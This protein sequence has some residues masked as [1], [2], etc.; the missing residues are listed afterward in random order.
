MICSFSESGI[1]LNMEKLKYYTNYKSKRFYPGAIFLNKN[2]KD[3]KLI[4]LGKSCYN[5]KSKHFIVV[6]FINTGFI[7]R[8]NTTQ[9]EH[10]IIDPY[11][12]SVYGKG[13]RG[14]GSYVTCKNY[15]QTKL[16]TLWYNML[17]RCYSSSYLEKTPSYIGCEVCKEWLNFQIFCKDIQTLPN[18]NNWEKDS[19]A[20]QLDKDYVDSNNKIYCKEKCSF[21]PTV[22]N[23]VLS[24]Y[25]VS[26]YKG[27]SPEGEEYLF[28]NMRLFAEEHG[29]TR[30]G[31]SSVISGRQKS[32]RGW[33]F[34]LIERKNKTF[35][36]E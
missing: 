24:N 15:K 28:S 2:T 32:H 3:Q 14:E 8:I 34:Y 4:V 26:K 11:E 9:L 18:Y 5:N 21:I 7:K 36:Q 17:M 35:T 33:K 10:F 25:S 23:V 29:M 12:P 19:A 16:G 20:W 6:K 31:I 1:Y 27:V 30:K 13:Y 22:L